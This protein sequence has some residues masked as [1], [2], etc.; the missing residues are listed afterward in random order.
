MFLFAF[1]QETM[2]FQAEKMGQIYSQEILKTSPPSTQPVPN[3]VLT[4]SSV[5]LT[6]PLERFPIDCLALESTWKLF[7]EIGFE[8]INV[9]N[10]RMPGSLGI[11]PRW[12][13]TWPQVVNVSQLQGMHLVGQL[14]GNSTTPGADFQQALLNKGDYPN[15]YT[16]VEIKPEDW[17]LLPDVPAGSQE[18]NIPWLSV[19]ALH[20]RGYIFD[21]YTPYMKMS[22]WNATSEI[23]GDDETRRRWVY[24]KEDANHPVL[25]WLSPSFA[26]YRLISGDA[27]YQWKQ[28]GQRILQIDG[29]IPKFAQDMIALWIRKIGA[30]SVVTTS[31]TFDSM[32][33][34][35][36]D[37]F[38]D[39]VTNPA[40]LHA[41]ITEDAAS[42]RMI[43]RIILDSKME[44]KRLVHVLEPF[45]KNACEW[46][47][48]TNKNKGVY[49]D[50][51]PTG[52][53]LKTK[54]LKE[55]FM[56]LGNF[57]P[58]KP[59]TWVDH[60]AR[61]LNV[62]DFEENREEI[63]NAHLLLAFTYAMQPGVFSISYDDLLGT[64]PDREK[65]PLYANIPCQL[66]NRGSFI[67]RLKSILQARSVSNIKAGE[68]I[69]V[70]SS[71]N[72]G[73][74]LLLHR[75]PKTGM[76]QLLVVNFSRCDVTETLNRK[77]FSNATAL[78]LMTNLAEQK[79][80]SSSQFSFNLPAMSGRAF[81]FQQKN[82]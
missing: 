17:N 70:I 58:I 62:R 77:E 54:L 63:T 74:L 8:A 10:L 23:L 1:A 44:T 81:I 29:R 50:L 60:C 46:I 68:L 66:S 45:D 61:A 51:Q 76:I 18:S 39:E 22:D 41:L 16:L 26:A 40:L 3:E 43:Y 59:T 7:K 82:Y 65:T 55:D 56:R 28:N 75:L 9:Q 13:Y 25:N 80:F 5:W 32:K 20:K 69:D 24:L 2:L 34:V 73:T 48:F 49:N 71:P 27:L 6:I 53:A 37:L 67:F 12:V 30:Y 72:P 42:L 11:D 79:V 38:Y 4:L 36:A 19:Q 15:L 64:L 57:D 47:E 21:R 35:S 31:G 33:N 52:E 78:D 14:I